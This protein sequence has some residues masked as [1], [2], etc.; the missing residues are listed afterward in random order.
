[1][2]WKMSNKYWAHV[3]VV[4][5]VM[6]SAASA[7]IVFLDDY[8][9][10]DTK[11]RF[12][13]E[14]EHYDSRTSTEDRGWWEVDA[15]T[16]KFIEGPSVGQTAPTAKSGGRVSYMET[17]GPTVGGIAPIDP[18]YYGPFM[19]YKMAIV[20]TGTYRLYV[21]WTGRTGGTDSLYAHILKP[22]GTLLSTAGVSYFLYHGRTSWTWDYRGV[23]NTTHCAGAGF[24]HSAVWTVTET[25]TYTIRISM[26]ERESVLDTLVFQTTNVS[27][28]TGSGPPE[29]EYLVG[30][31]FEVEVDIKPES[32][33]NPLNLKS[34]GILP[35]AILGS[36]DFD[37][38]SIDAA[39]IRL[40]DVAPVRSNYEDVS[41]PVI[42]GNECDCTEEG[43]DG[44]TDLTLKFE[45]EE[46]VAVIT[47]VVPDVNGD[48]ILALQL[49]GALTDETAI[50][51]VDCVVIRGKVP[52]SISAK[53][54]DINEDGTVN[55]LDLAALIAN[56]LKSSVLDE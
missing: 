54:S 17:L 19:D 39:S 31:T 53:K 3:F 25:G 15:S 23:K 43:P 24:P 30:P 45:T 41:A 42:D 28:P 10:D 44:Y 18:S 35:V 5:L 7:E 55:M 48:D 1:M 52:S 14:A 40:L 20:T 12:V 37:V 13:M 50:Q 22:D 21:R 4:L 32:C 16:L 29:S 33:P 27:G 36:E 11:A 9:A 26:R 46:I 6:V 8:A 51:G 49:T 56:W 47:D 34:K 38:N 2:N